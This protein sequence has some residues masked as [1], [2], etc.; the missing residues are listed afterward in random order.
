MENI[1]PR[2]LQKI[3]GK[4]LRCCEDRVRKYRKG[5]LT[6]EQIISRE[7]LP[8]GKKLKVF[9]VGDKEWTVPELMKY[10]NI[11]RRAAWERLNDYENGYRDEYEVFK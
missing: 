6:Y 7:N 2:M 9:M 8:V 10:K 5:L 4:S 3:N 11:G 1:S